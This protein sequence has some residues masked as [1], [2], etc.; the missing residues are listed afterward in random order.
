MAIIEFPI[1]GKP[2][3]DPLDALLIAEPQLAALTYEADT[4]LDP[5]EFYYLCDL[6]IG[7]PLLVGKVAP[8][9][10]NLAR[11]KKFKRAVLTVT[12]VEEQASLHIALESYWTFDKLHIKGI[13]KHK[14]RL[15]HLYQQEPGAPFDE[16]RHAESNKKIIAELYDQGYLG[17]TITDQLLEDEKNKTITV[18]LRVDRG[19]HYK[20][21]EV[22]VVIRDQHGKDISSNESFAPIIERLNNLDG[23][24]YS[25]ERIAE[26]TKQLKQQLQL[27]GYLHPVIHL[28]LRQDDKEYE[29]A[30]DFLVQLS[31]HHQFVFSGNQFFTNE[32]LLKLLNAFGVMNEPPP[33]L[34]A[35]EIE[36]LY[37]AHGFTDVHVDIE[38][39]ADALT[40]PGRLECAHPELIEGSKREHELCRTSQGSEHA[41]VNI[42]EGERV[43]IREVNVQKADLIETYSIN[44]NVIPPN[45]YYETELVARGIES[46]KA[47]FRALG[48]W[49]VAVISQQ[50]DAKTG[51]LNLSIDVGP[52][53]YLQSLTI[54]QFPQLLEEEPFACVKIDEPLDYAVIQRQRMWFTTY[55][56]RNGYMY[57]DARPSIALHGEPGLLHPR[58]INVNLTW[59]IGGIAEP[60]RFGK[61]IVPGICPIPFQHLQTE[62]AFQE[63]DVWSKEKMEQSVSRL[64]DLQLFSHIHLY[65]EDVALPAGEKP[66]M[67]NLVPDDPFEFRL[68]AGALGIANNFIWRDGVTYKVGG[69]FL[70]KN[71]GN[72]GGILGMDCDF[73]IYEQRIAGFYRH[74]WLF[75][76]HVSTLIKGYN[77]KFT[78]P[79][80]VGRRLPLYFVTQQ[81]GLVGLTHKHDIQIPWIQWG[82][83]AVSTLGTNIGFEWVKTTLPD[84]AG[85]DEA[86]ARYVQAAR[87]INFAPAL[88][89][90]KIPYFY[91][92]P[93]IVLDRLD[94]KLNPTRGTF[95]VA[96]LKCVASLRNK[97]DGRE[98]SSTSFVKFLA[99][100]LMVCA[101]LSNHLG[102]SYSGWPR[103]QSKV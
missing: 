3:L 44:T 58:R 90:V 98:T 26:C 43:I 57:A 35:A 29:V 55:L 54:P 63:G 24:K 97:V 93:T 51:I 101:M 4:K 10:I 92:E 22:N 91:I 62:L 20:I 47:Q 48:H 95:T 31:S 30:L 102:I 66:I 83:R 81:G 19:R 68:R 69:S 65:P 80:M 100:A 52:R 13:S 32:R 64:R 71:V 59:S 38:L 89:G 5:P 72:Q 34:L 36:R 94:N 82:Q 96:T 73:F 33:A 23:K 9:L 77:N 86:R 39:S 103:L 25:A 46:I 40:E 14:D 2:N 67:L 88:D 8:T 74:P 87:A 15:T 16:Q 70:Y 75:G 17:A 42:Q 78:Q 61:T 11:K 37:R 7:Q 27:F 6:P 56:H 85:D 18:V 84:F 99:Q 41:L 79:V 21:E 28:S 12:P 53:Y 1:G 45:S 50:F 60:V 49:D 76:K